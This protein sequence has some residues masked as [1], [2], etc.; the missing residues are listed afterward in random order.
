MRV[1]IH[2]NYLCGNN[3]FTLFYPDSPKLT[4][5]LSAER[6]PAD[7]NMIRHHFELRETI[8]TILADEQ[9]HID[10]AVEGI[11]GARQ[12][13]ERCIAGDPFFRS[14]FEPYIPGI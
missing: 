5:V 8:A 9:S 13:V 4:I 3:S 12:V 11:I 7:T 10:A 6:V 2:P 14:T 1:V